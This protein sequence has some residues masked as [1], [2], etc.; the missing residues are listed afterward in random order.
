M[1]LRKYT[2]QQLIEA[3]KES[4][5]IRETLT[6]LNVMPMGGNYDI[7]RKAVKIYNIDTTHFTGGAGSGDKTRGKFNPRIPL[8]DL[9]QENVDYGSHKLRIRLI[10]DNVF[11]HRCSNC[12]LTEWQGLPI[13]IEL[14]H[15]NG[16]N[17]DNR[18]ENLRL[19][20]PNCHA[21]T[22]TYRGSNTKRKNQPPVS[23]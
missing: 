18:I 11:E 8:E 1:K 3:V 20:C 21:L 16:I 6:K 13:P 5:S 19:L 22:P 23:I 14:D 15:I 9:L 2:L 12:N 4:S 7:F 10:R 17:N